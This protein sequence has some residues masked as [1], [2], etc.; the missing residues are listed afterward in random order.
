[1]LHLIDFIYSMTL[2]NDIELYNLEDNFD[3]YVSIAKYANNCLPLNIIQNNIFKE[4]R[5][6]KK[7]S[8]KNYI[9]IFK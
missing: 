2:G 9:I 7:I 4:F 1:M 8:L 6:K 3:M 5:I